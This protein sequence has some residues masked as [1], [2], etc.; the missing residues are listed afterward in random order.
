MFNVFEFIAIKG[1][2]QLF[3]NVLILLH[4]CKAKIVVFRTIAII[5]VQAVHNIPLHVHVHSLTDHGK[6]SCVLF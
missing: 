4:K 5:A 3:E 2:K 6:I 1:A